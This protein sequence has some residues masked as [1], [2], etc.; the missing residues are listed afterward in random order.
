M[1]AK[2]SEKRKCKERNVTNKKITEKTDFI[3][4]QRKVYSQL[5]ARYAYLVSFLRKFTFFFVTHF[6]SFVSN[7]QIH[8]QT[9]DILHS[10]LH[11]HKCQKTFKAQSYSSA[12][13]RVGQKTEPV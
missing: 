8:F 13:Y 1:F 7:V 9:R 6:K 12:I 5:Y 2:S 4:T 3:V 11:I 10:A